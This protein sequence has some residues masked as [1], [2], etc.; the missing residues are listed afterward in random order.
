MKSSSR[1]LFL[2]SIITAALAPVLANVGTAADRCCAHCGRGARHCRKVC[3]LVCEDKKIT[4]ICWGMQCEE[5]CVPGPSTPDCKHCEMVYPKTPE[6]KKISAQPKRFV[7]TSW[8]PGRS[9][10]VVT[11]RRLMKKTVTKTV[12]SF[13]WVIEDACQE[14]IAAIEPVT[15][16][17]GVTVPAAPEIEG[18][19]VV[20]AITEK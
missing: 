19:Y 12:P 20:A 16:P 17:K 7:W 4:T 3:R 18:A 8:I 13:K 2:R 9:A 5:I 11:K 1:R 15:V 6:D 14:C 10:D